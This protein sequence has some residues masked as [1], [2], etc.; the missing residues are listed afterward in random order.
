M[1]IEIK[2]EE[3]FEVVVEV[4]DSTEDEAVA[5]ETILDATINSEEAITPPG[6]R[7]SDYLSLKLELRSTSHQSKGS[8][9]SSSRGEKMLQHFQL[10]GVEVYNFL[11]SQIFTSTKLTWKATRLF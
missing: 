2:A 5:E 7:P 1:E 11:G 9:G 10:T 8:Q 6:R 4:E 3:T